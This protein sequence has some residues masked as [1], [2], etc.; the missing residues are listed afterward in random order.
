[1]DLHVQQFKNQPEYTKIKCT[2]TL[3]S[4]ISKFTLKEKQHILRI[5][6]NNS[7]DY[8][9]NSYGYFFNLNGLD[10]ETF[11]KLWKCVDLI[12]CN[13]DIIKQMDK[14]REELIIYYT[15]LI[16]SNLKKTKQDKLNNY[17]NSLI[18]YEINT[19]IKLSITKKQN[20]FINNDI[21]PDILI[22]EYIKKRNKYPKNSVYNR[23]A[24]IIKNSKSNK[25]IE[26]KEEDD[27]IDEISS[28]YDGN[29]IEEFDLNEEI[30]I[31]ENVDEINVNVD[32]D[33]E[34][35]VDLNDIT[36]NELNPDEENHEDETES[37]YSDHEK[38]EEK[39]EEKDDEKE[40]LIYKQNLQF[41]KKLLN[42][43]GFIFNENVKCL[44]E[45]EP[46]IE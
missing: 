23:I 26:K 45:F 4:N 42:K 40:Q 7:V 37:I 33:V 6:K 2:K 36:D 46:Y 13:R 10:E 28:E 16:E 31:D 30:D 38:E 11:N 3:I 44:L 22:K 14:K 20:K 41:Y 17:I 34:V 27:D 24:T 19:N 5:L 32:I 18:L 29:E 9:K 8:S 12:E 39:E 43:Q 35:D 21:D 25:F 1:M 15:S